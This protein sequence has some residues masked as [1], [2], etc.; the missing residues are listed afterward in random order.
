M[1]AYIPDSHTART[2]SR[3]ACP[4]FNAETTRCRRRSGK[5]FPISQV[6]SLAVYNDSTGPA[7]FAADTF[8]TDALSA[9]IPRLAKLVGN[10]WITVAGGVGAN[11]S[12]LIVLP[13]G[14]LAVG[15]S[16]TAVGGGTVPGSGPTN[17]L[18][19]M[20]CVSVP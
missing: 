8:T 10:T 3:L 20:D 11:P 12:R 4:T 1:V 15:G 13:D 9:L 6:R 18:A 17:G 5:A 19:F 2:M 14:R 16:F 7:L